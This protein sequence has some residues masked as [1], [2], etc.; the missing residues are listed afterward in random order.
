MGLFCFFDVILVEPGLVSMRADEAGFLPY[1][2]AF[3]RP[4][5]LL[6]GPTARQVRQVTKIF[7]RRAR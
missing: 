6:S 4:L 5:N 3:Q 1:A 7:R 2:M